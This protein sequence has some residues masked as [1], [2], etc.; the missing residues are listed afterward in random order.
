[1]KNSEDNVRTMIDREN[2]LINARLSW[3]ANFYGFLAAAIAFLWDK[4]NSKVVVC[5]F[6]GLGI[7]IAIASALALIGASR[8]I[9]RLHDWWGKNKPS[10]YS[11]PGV[12]G[13]PLVSK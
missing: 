9:F 8:A 13:L 10:D 3:M 6:C 4:P 1:M 2:D 11:G 7:V 5:I 12:S